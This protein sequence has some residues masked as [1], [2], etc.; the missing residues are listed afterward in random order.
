MCSI[1]TVE[2][3]KH[4]K[5]CSPEKRCPVDEP[6]NIMLSGESGANNLIQFDS[7]DMKY[8]EYVNP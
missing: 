7:I 1:R 5:K 6:E 2:Y 8:L 3:F 4:K